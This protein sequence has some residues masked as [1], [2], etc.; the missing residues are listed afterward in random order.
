MLS[1]LSLHNCLLEVVEGVLLH[2]L[3]ADIVLDLAAEQLGRHRDVGEPGV[4]VLGQRALHHA[5][6]VDQ[7]LQESITM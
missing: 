5:V 7:T 1:L 3:P 4:E 6:R 2:N